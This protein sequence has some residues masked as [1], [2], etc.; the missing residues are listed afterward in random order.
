LP[1]ARFTKLM[2]LE[3]QGRAIRALE[4]PSEPVVPSVGVEEEQPS[5]VV[6]VKRRTTRELREP[7]LLHVGLYQRRTAIRQGFTCWLRLSEGQSPEET[8]T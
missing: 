8:E 2:L 7:E 4:V 6:R 3:F 1:T 5:K